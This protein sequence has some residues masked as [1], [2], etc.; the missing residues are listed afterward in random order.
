MLTK[1]TFQPRLD[2]HF[3]LGALAT[4]LIDPTLY[5]KMKQAEP[6]Y[7]IKINVGEN[8]SPSSFF[9]DI[10]KKKT[11]IVENTEIMK[12]I[13]HET[14]ASLL[15]QESDVKLSKIGVK[16]ADSRLSPDYI[17]F[18]RK[19]IVELTTTVNTDP[20]NA[21]ERFTQK[22]VHY[23]DA[24]QGT[25]FNIGV[26]LVGETFVY[27]NL[28]MS[29]EM[30][31]ALCQRCRVG[32]AIKSKIERFLGVSL[33]PNDSTEDE[34]IVEQV[35]R[36]MKGN[37]KTSQHFPLTE[38]LSCTSKPTDRDFRI[39]SKILKAELKASKKRSKNN[40]GELTDYLHSYTGNSRTDMKRVC[41]IPMI[42]P[43]VREP[44]SELSHMAI[45]DSNM[46][47]WLK[48]IWT[49]C[50]EVDGEPLKDKSE[51][52]KDA[53]KIE[54]TEDSMKH[55]VQKSCSFNVKL[56]A[57][58]LEEASTTGLYGKSQKSGQLYRENKQ[59][60]KL[61]FHP[62]QTDTDDIENFINKL[63]LLEENTFS[64]VGK[65]I[66]NLIRDAK[67]VWKGAEKSTLSE[68]MFLT[69]SKTRLVTF[70]SM[71]TKLFTE[72]CYCYKYWIGR[73]DFY[74][75]K[76]DGIFMLIRCTGTHIFCSFAFPKSCYSSFDTGRIGPTL[77]E[78]D[79]WYFSDITS[80]TEPVVEHFVKA[81][82][83]MAS[84]MAH[85]MCSLEMD[86]GSKPSSS[87]TLSKD[88]NGILL[89][90][91]N[92]K[93]DAEELVTSQRYLTMGVLEDLDPNPYRFVE[94]L[95]EFIKSRL[96]AFLVKKTVKL[97]KRYETPPIRMLVKDGEN[98]A[99]EYDGLVGLFSNEPISFKRKIE[100]FYY[101]YVIS[102]EKGRGGDRNFK[103]MKKIVQQ[104]YV[105]RDNNFPEFAHEL[106]T[107]TNQT[108]LPM[109]KTLCFVMKERL[110]ESYGS[111]WNSVME[112]KIIERLS[113]VS[114][115][116]LATLKV[117][118]RTY[119][120]QLKIPSVDN[121]MST[122][123]IKDRLTKLNP[124]D[125]ASRPRVMESLTA[126]IE[127]FKKKTK[128]SDVRHVM[129]LVPWCL[130][131]I[132]KRG[133]FY[134]DI[135]PKAQH[136]GDREIHVLEITMRVCQLYV[137]HIARSLC[138]MVQSDT[139][140]HPKWKSTFVKNHYS[141]AESEMDTQ[142]IT[143]GKSA[144]AAKWCQR[145]HASK[146]AA[147]FACFLPTWML[148][149]VLRI[150]YLWTTK[151]I[152]F[153][154]Q[155]VA[156]FMSNKAVKSNPIYERMR[157][158]FFSGTGIFK[159]AVSNRMTIISGMMQG[160]LHYTSSFTHGVIQEAMILM[161]TRVLKHNNIKSVITM[162]QGSDDSAELISTSG[163][164]IKTLIRVSVTM[165]HWKENVS[166][167]IGIYTS[168]A[169]SC[170][171]SSDM[172][173]Y[174][175]E[176]YTRKNS[177]MPTFRWVSACL[178]VGVVE[179]F[180]DR[181][182]N[183]YGTST[184]V[185]ESGGKV[186]ETAII[187]E[188]QAWMHY[189]MIG[190][191]NHI[192]STEVSI[193][194]RELKDPALGYF[195]LDSDCNAGITGIDF[196]LYKY[197]RDTEYGY[198]V[199]A[200]RL[201]TA[202]LEMF[203]EDT[204]DP[205]I[206]QSLRRI[207]LKFGNHKIFTSLLRRMSAPDLEDL[208]KQVEQNPEVL[209]Y[210]P[211]SWN[212]SKLNIFM[213]LFEPGVKESLSRHSATARVLS[214]SAYMIS[215]PCFSKSGTNQKFSL[216]RALLSEQLDRIIEKSRKLSKEEVF[217]FSEEY[218]DTLND[219]ERILENSVFQ[220]VNIKSRSKQTIMVFDRVIT[221]VPI[222][223][224]CK[225]KWFGDGW[226]GLTLRQFDIK[227][228][229]L[230]EKFSFIKSS[231]KETKECLGMSEIQLKNFL[232]S[233]DSRPRKLTLMDTAARGSGVKSTMTR[234][235]WPNIKLLKTGVDVEEEETA[236]SL[237]SKLFSI[238]THWA[239]DA[240]KRKAVVNLLSRS[241]ILK[242][243][244]V[245]S[246]LK[247]LKCI[248][249]FLEQVPLQKIIDNIVS[250]RIGN[251][252]VF[253]IRQSG[254]GD[255][256][257][258]Y[259]EWKGIM[260]SSNIKIEL[261]GVYC[262]RITVSNLKE[263]FELG[264]SLLEF[265][266]NIRA[267]F[268]KDLAESDHWLSPD[269][270]INGGKG[271]M[272]AIPIKIDDSLKV[273]IF[274]DV[275]EW[276][277]FFDIRYNNIR[278]RAD[279][280]EGNV[281]TL[282]SD[283][284]KSYEWDP[285]YRIDD[286]IFGHWNNSEP[287]NAEVINSELAHYFNRS[288]ASILKELTKI[289]NNSSHA[290][291]ASGW[292]LQD[293]KVALKSFFSLKYSDKSISENNRPISK[294]GLSLSPVLEEFPDDDLM[295]FQTG[296]VQVDTS[297]VDEM[298][299]EEDDFE[300]DANFNVEEYIDDHL[301]MLLTERE[302]S[303][304]SSLDTMPPTN[305]CLSSLD[306]ISRALTGKSL[307]ESYSDC[308]EDPEKRYYGLMGKIMTLVTG[309]PRMIRPISELERDVFRQEE[310]AT[311]ATLSIRTT[312]DLGNLN[313]DEIKA[314][315]EEIDNLLKHVKQQGIRENLLQTRLRYMNMLNLIDIKVSDNQVSKLSSREL[316]LWLKE[317]SGYFSKE[318]NMLYR[319]TDSAFILAIRDRLDSHVEKMCS[320]AMI[321]EFE[322][323]L[324]REAIPKPHLTTLFL[325]VFASYLEINLK[326]GPYC[327][328]PDGKVD[329]HYNP[330]S[331]F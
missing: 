20:K 85:Q 157:S 15:S 100:E 309:T 9:I 251:L 54:Q 89:L 6:K 33:N 237:R 290:V 155:F 130:G 218:E 124:E 98:S 294:S 219:I 269:G 80:Y 114:F 226:T 39:A 325:D 306:G 137:E 129:Q 50:L 176:W 258:G 211:R 180:I 317:E 161:Q 2:S 46:P 257:T 245:P 322:L 259:G 288:D 40:I 260:L 160:I 299:M 331:E 95:P 16:G 14:V 192:L 18:D 65:N 193:M 94:R 239:S 66:L 132:E 7:T 34:F 11:T 126:L 19:L 312:D 314:N 70:C 270:V 8:G 296:D 252:G 109:L 79:D 241:E 125:I 173:E 210:P 278:L 212:G 228:K 142:R 230:T 99:I 215:K 29:Q 216:Y 272:N 204:K 123:E 284:F 175:S 78:S 217:L 17:D 168:R 141:R 61:S 302:I 115:T 262:V 247:K 134:S 255:N 256:R 321:S 182:H 13:V 31:D 1:I 127:E 254:W 305:R 90:Y 83:Y 3:T 165:L 181:L 45:N 264:R 293:F 22:I 171:G 55:K 179:K 59:K 32:I 301:E 145:N 196:Q 35:I 297:I 209:Y 308:I 229:E 282:V 131:I 223:E 276:D 213:K 58:D 135:F 110:Q 104:E 91:L 5:S 21:E 184:N 82:P 153:P 170:I 313:E 327:T 75:K 200:N 108:N 197:H 37:P 205:S 111:D 67:S 23:K 214:A 222:I 232:V 295:F 191:S 36:S 158:E 274:D 220:K 253:T 92:N 74:V 243:K 28:L 221:D 263:K 316:I 310:E 248:S 208:V 236:S 320:R 156:N 38:I 298:G 206:S 150:L 121:S 188:C 42:E 249:D 152:C 275:L 68:S 56:T 51:T 318:M 311:S 159:D 149:S 201:A 326:V 167:H 207:R 144:D 103:I 323:G 307:R 315:V 319:L 113:K 27:T 328:N 199:G 72:I 189:I 268:P 107:K 151:V 41:N 76:V 25:G 289:N 250:D 324:Y 44:E 24:I 147:V 164:S 10:Y 280:G 227:W 117:S 277:W 81:G 273:T 292:K 265:L 88:M 96:T 203:S 287:M 234:L 267:K 143:I 174:N 87:K 279:A 330:S 244:T 231:R 133:F 154:L 77:F 304:Q 49:S 118:S 169:K 148:S 63:E 240:E 178:E 300:F 261:D 48:K 281:L 194:L 246:R 185:I 101:G 283:N 225:Q 136:G 26:V 102:K 47:V 235:F 93:T 120:G 73:S 119:E 183:F 139:L 84:I 202:E 57:Q 163:K 186:L 303:H 242:Q 146:F 286:K 53:M 266:K 60:N 140:M 238:I 271:I 166:K 233:I 86:L 285:I 162:A 177:I 64:A 116:E 172:I 43:F 105:Y 138:D 106:E 195:P 112:K 71:I 329:Y 62:L 12:K 30:V 187:Q 52:I 198:G 4:E 69:I 128:Q 224:M 291:S 190:L 97:M 122:E